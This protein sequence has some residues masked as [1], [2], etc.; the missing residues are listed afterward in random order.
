MTLFF[1]RI[2]SFV[3]FGKMFQLLIPLDL[4]ALFKFVYFLKYLRGD[5]S[6]CMLNVEDK[7]HLDNRSSEK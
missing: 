4:F 2:L 3:A 5:I 6:V 1:V 7:L